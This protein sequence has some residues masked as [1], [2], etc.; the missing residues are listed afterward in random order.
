ML[1]KI[2]TRTL[3]LMGFGECRDLAL[4]ALYSPC[5]GKYLTFDCLSD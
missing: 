1:Q 5:L 4:I 2:L 3:L